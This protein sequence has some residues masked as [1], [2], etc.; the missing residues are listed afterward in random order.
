MAMAA[1][2]SL[3][4]M[5]EGWWMPAIHIAGEELDGSPFF[6]PL[7]NERAQPGALMVDQRVVVS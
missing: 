2:A 5:G 7:H 3:H 1:G 4:N 6:R